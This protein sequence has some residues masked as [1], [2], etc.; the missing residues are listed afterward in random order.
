MIE[1]G[2]LIPKIEEYDAEQGVQPGF[3]KRIILNTLLPV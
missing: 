1:T 2:D 3:T